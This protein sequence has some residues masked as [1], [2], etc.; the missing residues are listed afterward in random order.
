[1]RAFPV[2]PSP[3]EYKKGFEAIRPRL[4]DMQLSLLRA[5]YGSPGHVA[6]V[7]ELARLCGIE[8]WRT[9]NRQYGEVAKLLLTEMGYGKPRNYDGE[10]WLI[11]ICIWYAPMAMFMRPEVAV[12][13]EELGWVS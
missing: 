13:L 5:H 8:S 6:T 7:Q 3:Q 10:L 4:S 1:M 2:S 11:G 9:V 12:A